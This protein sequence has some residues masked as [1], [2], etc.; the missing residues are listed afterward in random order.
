MTFQ[1]YQL[2]IIAIY[3]LAAWIFWKAKGKYRWIIGVSVV[4]LTLFNP[5]KHKQLGGK[6]FEYKSIPTVI[7]PRI[8]HQPR[9]TENQYL[10]LK[11][12]SKAIED[13]Y[14]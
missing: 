10:N 2:L 13:A 11:R 1:P 7:L 12:E 9:N 14:N 5:I 3:I 6:A 8:Y 4:L